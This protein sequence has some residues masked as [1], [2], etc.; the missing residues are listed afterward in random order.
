M[1]FLK[2]GDSAAGAIKSG[3]TTRRAAKMICLD[4][5]HPDIEQFINWKVHEEQKVA[6]LVSG[7]KTIKRLIKELFEAIHGWENESEKFDIELNKDL[8][9]VVKASRLASMP[10]SYVYRIIHLS[11]QGYTG[12]LFDEYDTDWN[13]E[14]YQ[15]VGG[16]NS[17]NSVRLNNAFMKQL[18]R[19]KTGISTGELKRSKQKKKAESRFLAKN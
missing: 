8:R 13:S 14:A 9:S 2:I 3:G 16:Q 6:A 18:N 7:S 1:S 19:A 5:D 11:K 12:V 15:T 4:A 17:N 10:F